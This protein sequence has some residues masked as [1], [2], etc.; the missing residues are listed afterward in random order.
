VSTSPGIEFGLLIKAMGIS[1]G[2]AAKV[3]QDFIKSGGKGC[4]GWL[5]HCDVTR[6]KITDHHGPTLDNVMVP[7]TRRCRVSGEVPEDLRVVHPIEAFGDFGDQGRLVSTEELPAD[8]PLQKKVKRAKLTRCE[9][10][11]IVLYT[12]A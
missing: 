3:F 5:T 8:T 1:T 4:D 2:P 10:L 12:G 11:A 7:A 6:K 9:I